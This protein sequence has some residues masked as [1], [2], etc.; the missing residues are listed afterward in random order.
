MTVNVKV[1]KNQLLGFMLMFS[2]I[3]LSPF[4][5]Y[6]S[7]IPQP[8]HIFMML[9]GLALI[10]INKK[11]CI[12]IL[13]SNKSLIVFLGLV[14]SI[15]FVYFLEYRKYIFIVNSMY[16]LYGFL[17]FFSVCCIC[18]D[19]W[20]ASWTKK[21]ILLQMCF[22]LT[23]YL[24]GWGEFTYWP[25][26]QF[27][28]NGPNQLANFALSMLIVYVALERGSINTGVL[29]AYFLVGSV[30]FMTGARSSYLAFMPMI[31]ILVYL[32]KGNYKKQ[33]LLIILPIL[34]Y[35]IF[36]ALNLPWYIP[37]EAEKSFDIGIK[38]FN[39]FKELC[40]SCSS[41]DYY[42]IEY[43]LR[44]RGYLRLLDFPH[45]LFYGAGQGMD[46]RFGSLDETSYEIHSSLFSVLFY[47][48]LAGLISFLIA[49]YKLF[50]SK[51]NIL[52]LSPLFVYGLFTYGLRSPY[53][54]IV[55]GFVVFITNIFD[56]DV[57]ISERISD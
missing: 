10:V 25:R 32:A 18:N 1:K 23:F 39:R 4:Y 14:I 30:V 7:G 37:T 29:A 53:F 36:Q 16:W 48:G 55:L 5:F 26:Y 46:E 21:L 42:S 2:I 24:A 52:L 49:V 50:K 54:W 41:T 6:P 31:F 17:I 19:K 20:L 34:I 22:V 43:Q 56:S 12:L 11:E 8:S 35:Y 27:F 3:I 44:A 38:T 13:K 9:V 15:N 51:M 33:F 57:K 40:T 45:Y 47:Y 28:F